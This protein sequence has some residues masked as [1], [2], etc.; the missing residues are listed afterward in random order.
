MD[1]KMLLFGLRRHLSLNG[2]VLQDMV[3]SGFSTALGGL[4]SLSRFSIGSFGYG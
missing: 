1:R 4:T 3:W 2:F